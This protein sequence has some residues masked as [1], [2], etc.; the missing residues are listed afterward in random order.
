[1]APASREAAQLVPTGTILRGSLR[2]YLKYMPQQAVKQRRNKMINS[3]RR[4]RVVCFTDEMKPRRWNIT[5]SR[6]WAERRCAQK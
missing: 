6:F 3:A 1:M 4:V 5:I 2:Y